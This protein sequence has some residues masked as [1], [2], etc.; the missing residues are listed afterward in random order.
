MPAHDPD[1][2]RAL[3]ALGR[4]IEGIRTERRLTQGELALRTGLHESYIDVLEGGGHNPRWG[5]VLKISVGLGVPLAE[6][7][8]RAEEIE[9]TL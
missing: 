9:R 8:R 3:I 4:A 6:L 1:L 5:T 2:E 7:A